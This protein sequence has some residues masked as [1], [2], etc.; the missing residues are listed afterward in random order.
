[1]DEALAKLIREIGSANR[2]WWYGINVGESDENSLANLLGI[3]TESLMCLLSVVGWVSRVATTNESTSS[4]WRVQERKIETFLDRFHL[5]DI[6]ALTKSRYGNE[7]RRHFLEVGCDKTSASPLY[8]FRNF[9]KPSIQ[10][11]KSIAVQTKKLL[12]NATTKQ[13][14]DSSTGTTTNPATLIKTPSPRR[15]RSSILKRPRGAAADD[16]RTQKRVSLSSETLENERKRAMRM[17]NNSKITTP[18]TNQNNNKQHVSRNQLIKQQLICHLFP[19]VFKPEFFDV[20]EEYFLESESFE[21]QDL[22]GALASVMKV[23]YEHNEKERGEMLGVQSF[24]TPNQKLSTPTLHAYGIDTT[25]KRVVSD[26]VR[27]LV[28]LSDKRRKH[29]VLTTRMSNGRM[30]SLVR[31]PKSTN[32][33]S[34]HEQDRHFKWIDQVLEALV[35]QNDRPRKVLK[36]STDVRNDEVDELEEDQLEEG[37][38]EELTDMEYT[39]KNLFAHLGKRFPNGVKEAVKQQKFACVAMDPVATFAMWSDANINYSQARLIARHLKYWFG[40]PLVSSP[41]ELKRVL[42]TKKA[43]AP[44]CNTLQ[45]NNESIEWSVRDATQVLLYFCDTVFNR[46]DTRQHWTSFD[47]VVSADHGKGFSCAHAVLICRKH[48]PSSNKWTEHK[49][50]YSLADARCKKDTYEILKSTYMPKLDSA[51]SQLTEKGGIDVWKRAQLNENEEWYYS[52]LAGSRPDQ[53]S[54]TRFYG[55]LPVEVFLAGD[56]A[57]IMTN[58]GREGMSSCWCAFCQLT[59]AEWQPLSHARGTKWSLATM[60]AQLE[61]NKTLDENAKGA[62]RKG[63]KNVPLLTAVD[64]CHVSMPVL[65]IK[66]GVVNKALD[67]LYSDLQAACEIYTAAWIDLETEWLRRKKEEE[68]VVSELMEITRQKQEKQQQQQQQVPDEHI[69]A[70]I[71]LLKQSLKEKD[72][73]RKARAKLVKEAKLEWDKEKSV[74]ENS[75]K[76]GQPVYRKFEEIER[77]HGIDRAAFHGGALQGNPCSTVLVDRKFIFEEIWVYVRDLPDEQKWVDNATIKRVIDAYERL[78]GHLDATFS[79]LQTPRNHITPQQVLHLEHHLKHASSVWRALDIPISP[80]MHILEDHA[81]DAVKR[82]GGIGDLG[83]DEGER[84]HQTGAQMESRMKSL[85]HSTKGQVVAQLEVMTKNDAVQDRLVAVTKAV[86]R[87]VNRRNGEGGDQEAPK[88]YKGNKHKALRD[89]E[90]VAL[91]SMF[92]IQEEKYPRLDELRHQKLLQS[93][94]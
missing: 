77:A 41:D 71:A 25:N 27:D 57:Q 35:K 50:S 45:L 40:C 76:H 36:P 61:Y 6:T 11:T 83:E 75:R 58:Y 84:A 42:V 28:T 67:C 39:A 46:A 15:R 60:K 92:A 53:P 7:Q 22:A 89:S 90:R 30:V 33:K 16:K 52:R 44:E 66:L 14:G 1:M 29:D 20:M 19:K 79:I 21:E 70:E 73:E 62:L 54:D 81:L 37:Q 87:N 59:K 47:M 69:A 48:D 85:N 32:L 94:S 93:E 18:A 63:I 43:V 74:P 13:A 82:Y 26:L 12:L 88:S 2:P 64:V 23:L 4:S 5:R 56:L 8:V 91:L 55:G 3:S 17:E 10:N 24:M 38:E 80:K 31:I 51:L 68:Q 78:M 34:F 9:T 65:H 49:D 86:Q 72:G